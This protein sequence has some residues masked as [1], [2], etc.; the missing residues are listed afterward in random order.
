MKGTDSCTVKATSGRFPS[1]SYG[2]FACVLAV[3]SPV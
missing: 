3:T 2:V 1:V